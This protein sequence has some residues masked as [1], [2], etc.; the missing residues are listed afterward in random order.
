M[1]TT[2]QTPSIQIGAPQIFRATAV[3][4]FLIGAVLHA[5]RLVIGPDRLLT[6]YLT[7]PVDGAFG[8]LMLASAIAGWLSFRRFTGGPALCAG[9]IFALVVITFS[10]PIHLRALMVW[11]TEYMAIFPPW[12]SAAEIPMF[13]GLAYLVTRLPFAGEASRATPLH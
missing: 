5:A 10:I 8:F 12:Y 4:I 9:F 6:E 3:V 7:P 13:L 1:T 11:S 2:T